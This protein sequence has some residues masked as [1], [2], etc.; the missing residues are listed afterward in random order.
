MD[1]SGMRSYQRFWILTCAL[2]LLLCGGF[3]WWRTN[4]VLQ[5]LERSINAYTQQDL[6]RLVSDSQYFLIEHPELL[7]AN[8][9][10]DPE[11]FAFLERTGGWPAYLMRRN[12]IATLEL[13]YL[14]RRYGAID[15]AVFLSSWN[16]LAFWFGDAA[17]QETWERSRA[18]HAPEFQDFVARSVAQG[19]AR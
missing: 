4:H 11:F 12:V 3:A 8:L 13:L 16:H 7:P 19:P 14:Q 2:L 9:A 6:V 5:H 17:F 1:D 18:L 15:E 10:S